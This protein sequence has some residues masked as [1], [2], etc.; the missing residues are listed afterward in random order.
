MGEQKAKPQ[1]QKE[2]VSEDLETAISFVKDILLTSSDEQKK[3]EALNILEKLN[4][5]K[6]YLE[7]ANRRLRFYAKKQSYGGNRKWKKKQ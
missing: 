7:W 5:V 3:K 6:G 1:K 4:N 2:K